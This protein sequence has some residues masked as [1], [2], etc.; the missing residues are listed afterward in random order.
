MRVCSKWLAVF[1]HSFFFGLY[2][3]VVVAFTITRSFLP[4][5]LFC[6]CLVDFRILH[7][8]SF[9]VRPARN[10]L[11]NP[12][13]RHTHTHTS[14]FIIF[15]SRPFV[16]RYYSAKLLIFAA[17]SFFGCRCLVCLVFRPLSI[18]LH[19]V[20][21]P[22]HRR[23]LFLSLVHARFPKF[24]FCIVLTAFVVST[25]MIT[26]TAYTDK[27][28][29]LGRSQCENTTKKKCA[30]FSCHAHILWKTAIAN[31]RN[32]Q[33]IRTSILYCH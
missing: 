33:R 19:F 13:H 14:N 9:S 7:G 16:N 10:C 12:E 17:T 2:C 6:S 24:Y 27:Y 11:E 15:I 26:L 1:L 22:Q 3:I 20:I 29:A 23:L 5:R 31:A 30:C 21:I 4:Y 28:V 18:V 8:T 25:K 32:E